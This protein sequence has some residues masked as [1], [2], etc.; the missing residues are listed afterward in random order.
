MRG[1]RTPILRTNPDLVGGLDCPIRSYRIGKVGHSQ[2]KYGTR[3]N[4][5]DIVAY[6]WYDFISVLVAFFGVNK[7]MTYAEMLALVRGKNNRSKRKIDNNTT[8]YIEYDDSVSVE[9][10]STKV[11]VLYPNGLVKLQTGGWMTPTTKDRMNRYSPVRVTQRK[12]EWYVSLS[13]SNGCR[14]EFPF[15]ENM[16][17]QG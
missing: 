14:N 11:V 1:K 6:W 4:S 15:M 17:V 7:M 3:G 10:H 9:L 2:R 16:V 5:V 8:A 13:C 12:G